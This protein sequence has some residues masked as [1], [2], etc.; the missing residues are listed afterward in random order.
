V[1]IVLPKITLPWTPTASKKDCSVSAKKS[2]SSKTKPNVLQTSANIEQKVTVT[3][4]KE[5][6]EI[7][8]IARE[9]VLAGK[10]IKRSP[11][12]VKTPAGLSE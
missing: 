4:E 10:E 9:N 11:R 5:M 7:E 2:S 6:H 3:K 12:H 8:R 1:E